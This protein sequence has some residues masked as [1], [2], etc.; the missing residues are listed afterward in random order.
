M[1]ISV[2]SETSRLKGVIVH[3]PG[4]EVSLVNPELKDELLFDDIVFED[5]A[6][7]EHQEMLDIFRAAMP[8]GGAIYEIT[9]LSGECFA[10]EEAREFFIEQL[11]RSYPQGNLHAV[12][13]ELI[14]LSPEELLQF[15]VTGS[16]GKQRFVLQPAPN[17][18]FTRDLAAVVNDNILISRAAKDARVREFLLMEMLVRYHPLFSEQQPNILTIAEQET[19]EGGDV[20][21]A[22]KDL[23]LIG[24]SERTSFSGLMAAAEGLLANGVQ[25][26]LAVD[27]PKQRSSMHLDTIFTFTDEDECLVFPPAITE[28]Q[29]NVV[30]LTAGDESLSAEIMPSLKVALEECLER[31]F[32]F[33]NCGGESRTN[34]FREQWTDGANVFALA[35]GVVVGYE[36]NTNTF[37]TLEQHGYELVNQFE[38]IEEYRDRPFNPDDKKM[39]ID[40]VGNELC[41][42]RGGARCMTLPI[43]RE[44]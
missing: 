39:A 40:F 25:T 32:T 3:T 43:F 31:E 24:M 12:R 42:G 20:L 1:K 14:A 29:E 13:Q 22:S 18:L 30:R 27:I 10:Q 4:E 44:S 2:S 21:V 15:A 17:L 38:F 23:V 28:R 11:I 26:V 9:D 33:I 6:R 34:Q 36:R 7:R 8:S 41:R 19:L 5:D 35:P 37:K 16:T